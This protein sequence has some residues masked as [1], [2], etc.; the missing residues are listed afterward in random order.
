MASRPPRSP[1]QSVLE[2]AGQAR[3]GRACLTSQTERHRPHH[4]WTC[5][6]LCLASY[7]SQTS[8]K[9]ALARPCV[10]PDTRHKDVQHDQ[11]QAKPHASHHKSGQPIGKGCWSLP[12]RSQPCRIGKSLPNRG[13]GSTGRRRPGGLPVSSGMRSVGRPAQHPPWSRRCVPCWPG[14]QPTRCWMHGPIHWAPWAPCSS[15]RRIFQ[16]TPVTALHAAGRKRRS[17]QFLRH[18]PP[19]KS[20]LERLLDFD[21]SP[22]L[23]VGAVQVES[24][25][26]HCFDATRKRIGSEHIMVSGALPPAF[27]SDRDQRPARLGWWHP[28]PAHRWNASGATNHGAT[29]W[30][31]S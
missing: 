10:W 26:S 31:S 8:P 5:V 18:T 23:S 28:S 24:G 3:P 21:R 7:W 9:P 6:F 20:T 19:L 4:Q 12:A 22:R 25:N 30:C 15:A 2:V 29:A 13:P 16:D 1:R 27:S 17:D 14:V 11:P